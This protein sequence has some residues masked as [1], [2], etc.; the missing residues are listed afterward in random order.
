MEQRTAAA[1]ELQVQ[2]RGF[3]RR[4]LEVLSDEQDKQRCMLKEHVADLRASLAEQ[5]AEFAAA[6]A[7]FA[8]GQRVCCHDNNGLNLPRSA[9]CNPGPTAF[10]A[11]TSQSGSTRKARIKCS[12]FSKG[13]L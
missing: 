12:S 1:A 3:L 13:L 2:E 5:R 4:N 7:E 9:W 8:H 11:E 10:V 6:L